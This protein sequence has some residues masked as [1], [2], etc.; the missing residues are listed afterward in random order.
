M[1]GV[2]SFGKIFTLDSMSLTDIGQFILSI[3]F[4][5][6]FTSYIFKKISYFIGT[7]DH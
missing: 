1:P 3:S 2:F 7:V 4:C 6:F 5:D